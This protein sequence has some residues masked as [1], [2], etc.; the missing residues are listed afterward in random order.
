M[1][2][3]KQTL[4]KLCAHFLQ[5][6]TQGM[7]DPAKPGEYPSIHIIHWVDDEQLTQYKGQGIQ[8][9]ALLLSIYP[10]GHDIH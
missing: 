7:Q 3:S 4:W 2:Q 1:P 8:V 6:E 10:K 9:L 5:L